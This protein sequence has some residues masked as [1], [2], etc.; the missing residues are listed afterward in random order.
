MKPDQN[1]CISSG[2]FQPDH[3]NLLN[4]AVD[5]I[6]KCLPDLDF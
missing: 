3:Q 6:Q 5:Q 2:F 1:N 4:T